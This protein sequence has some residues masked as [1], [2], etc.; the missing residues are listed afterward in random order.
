M[1]KNLIFFHEECFLF[2]TVALMEINMSSVD[3]YHKDIPFPILKKL[4][5]LPYINLITPP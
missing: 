1:N 2:V 4:P 3:N 5:S